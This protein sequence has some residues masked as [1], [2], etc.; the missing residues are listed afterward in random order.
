MECVPANVSYVEVQSDLEAIPDVIHV[1][2][3]RVWSISSDLSSATC[4]LVL[5]RNEDPGHHPASAGHEA[6]LKAAN[7]VLKVKFGISHV[8]IQVEEYKDGMSDCNDCKP[9]LSGHNSSGG[10]GMD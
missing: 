5:R 3:L 2:D 8:T 10:S 7:K 6:V 9:L 1:H 4:H